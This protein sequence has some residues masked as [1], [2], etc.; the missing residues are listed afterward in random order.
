MAG[1]IKVIDANAPKAKEFP[2]GD[3]IGNGKAGSRAQACF[4]PLSIREEGTLTPGS[5]SS[6]LH[7]KSDFQ[8][9]LSSILI[10]P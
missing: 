3:K 1:S 7:G 8:R 6:R 2:A 9:R 10:G 5:A 4:R